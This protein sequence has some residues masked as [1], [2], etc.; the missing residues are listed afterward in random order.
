[1]SN[2]NR[3]FYLG[4]IG[5]IVTI[6]LAIIGW[7]IYIS[8]QPSD[9]SISINP[10]QGSV[11]KGGVIQTTITV[12]GIH[13]Y[14]HP[15]SLSASGHPSDVVIAFIPPFGEATPAYASIMTITVGSNV[16]ADDY[17][18]IIKGT[19]ADGKEHAVT[20]TLTVGPAVIPLPIT[21]TPPITPPPTLDMSTYG[22]ETSAQ[23]WRPQTYADSQ[24]II[25]VAQTTTKTKFGAGAL[26]CTVNLKAGHA[27][28]GKGEAWVDMQTSPPLGVTAPVDLTSATVS[29]W[30]YLPATA[31]GDPSRPNGIQL[32]FKDKSWKNKYSSWKN[33]GADLQ[34]DQWS[35]ITV[36]MATEPW[37]WDDGCDLTQVRAVGVKI[38][39]GDGSVATFSG[40]IWIDA[41]NITQ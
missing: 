29:V 31:A 24:A 27:N 7:Y 18:I 34:T 17:T 9:F 41:Y 4:V 10:M 20:Y 16:P 1:M 40:S 11:Q 12:K 36:N 26:Q 23:G 39:A 25:S 38:G 19:G 13:R 6:I 28:Y 5:I 15:V 32:F 14:E 2:E 3:R 30:V 33:I 37:A 21:P 22:F 8:Y 35:Q